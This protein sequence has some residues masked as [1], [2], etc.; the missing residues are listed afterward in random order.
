MKKGR[1]IMSNTTENNA[2]G[3]E[4]K[5]QDGA[6]STAPMTVEARVRPIAPKENLLG[7]AN[8]TIN[9]CLVIEGLR[10]RQGKNG[11][12]VGMPG[13]LDADGKWR[14][15]CKPITAEFQ[16][17]IADTVR[18]EYAAAIERMA[19]TVAATKDAVQGIGHEQAGEVKDAPA[20]TSD[21]P[22]REAEADAPKAEKRE[23][24]AEKPASSLADTLKKNAEKAKAQPAKA[25]DAKAAQAL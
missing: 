24:A 12:N 15:T 18:S 7:F 17:Q 21:V 16:K 20:K 23:Q 13:T 10:I 14:D 25:A 1:I 9:D 19:E 5:E 22:S 4:A 11:I 6:I 3:A 8:V 2:A